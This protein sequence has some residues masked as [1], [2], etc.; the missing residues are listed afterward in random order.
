MQQLMPNIATEPAKTEIQ[1]PGVETSAGQNA[2][3]LRIP[4]QKLD[5]MDAAD[6]KEAE[7]RIEHI[8]SFYERQKQAFT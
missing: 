3:V 6:G 2:R 4:E 8:K 7:A 1:A 5:S